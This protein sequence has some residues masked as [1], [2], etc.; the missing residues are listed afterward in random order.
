MDY[1]KVIEEAVTRIELATGMNQGEI[2]K[3]LG[4]AAN[5]ISLAIGRG[6]TK[7]LIDKLQAKYP[8]IL[9]LQIAPPPAID[10]YEQALL[11]AVVTDYIKLKAQIT[12]RSVDEIAEE[13]D[14]NTKLILRDIKK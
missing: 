8:D 14:Q 3:D 12:K 4:Y 11:K 6:G 5:Y 1:A 2:S 7:K 9:G 13:L 10:Q